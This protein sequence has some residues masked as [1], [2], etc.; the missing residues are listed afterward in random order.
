[1]NDTKKKI[2]L[3]AK[4]LF[5]I[6]G[7]DQS[8]IQDIINDTNL[9]KGAIYHYFSSKEDILNY[10]TNEA[11]TKL[12]NYISDLKE[13]RELT[14]KEKISQ[15]I[16]HQTDNDVQQDLINHKWL[17]KIPFALVDELRELNNLIV[18]LVA[19][20]LKEGSKNNEFTCE[21][22]IKI[23]ELILFYFDI[24]LDPVLFNRSHKEV[25]DRIDFLNNMLLSMN[26]QLFDNG[27]LEQIKSAYRQ[28]LD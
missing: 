7:Y 15:L 5:A 3:T 24:L 11:K 1:M 28:L 26:I 10:I 23:A 6:K 12:L 21:Y 25:C 16:K 19:G 14:A 18:P 13:N 27:D 8:S 9:S 2:I 17:E 20:I 22:P 4:R